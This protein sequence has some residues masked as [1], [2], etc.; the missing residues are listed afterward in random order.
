M[1]VQDALPSP[2]A[3]LLLSGHCPHCPVMLA[4]LSELL[5][6]G[7]IGHLEAVNVEQRPVRAAELGVRGVPWLRL[8][9]FEL[10]GVRTEGELEIWARRAA[11]PEGLAEAF[12]DLLKEGGLSQVLRLL[13]EDPSRLGY[14]LPILANPEAGMNVRLGAGVAFEELAG[15]A[16]LAALVPQICELAGQ[17]DARVRA[18][19]C[20]VLGLSRSAMAR[21]CLEARFNDESAE[22]REIAA[23]SLAL[24]TGSW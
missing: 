19:A 9:P 15:S 20:H 21:P 16:A 4:A 6:R 23:D 14:L 13:A 5:K 11:A 1:P 17:R 12:H 24:I 7:L 10:T 22:V 8:G 18:D 3:L 2:D